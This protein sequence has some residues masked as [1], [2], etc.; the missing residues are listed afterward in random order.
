MLRHQIKGCIRLRDSEGTTLAVM[1]QK[2]GKRALQEVATLF[3]QPLAP[4]TLGCPTGRWGW[5]LLTHRGWGLWGHSS[6]GP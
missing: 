6:D 5:C 2:L 1:S 3:S 4:G